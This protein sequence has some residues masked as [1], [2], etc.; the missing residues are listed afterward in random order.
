[1]LDNNQIKQ[2]L[3]DWS[4][5]DTAP[6]NAVAREIELPAELNE[7]LAF[8][9]QGVR[10]CG[11]STL[12]TQLPKIYNIPLKQCYFCNFEDTRLVNYLDHSLL[13]AIYSVARAEIPKDKP[14]YFFLD[15]IQNVENWEKWIYTKL[16]RP[17]NNYFILTG[18]NSCLLSG[19]FASSLTG[20]HLTIE[21]FPFSFQEYKELY[22]ERTI[23]EYLQQGG[24]PQP[25]IS[26][27]DAKKI[28]QEYFN[29]IIL[30]DIAKRSHARN[31]QAIKQVVQMVYESTGSEFSYRKIAASTD[32]T[33]DTIKSYLT[34]AEQAYLLFECPYFAH[35][36][37]KRANKPKKYYPIDIGMMHAITTS[38]S[39]NLGKSLELAVFLHLKQ[40]YDEVFYW[41]ETGKGE[42]DFI[43]KENNVSIPIQV[44]TDTPKPRHNRALDN[45]YDAHPMSAE[46]VFISLSNIM[47]F[48]SA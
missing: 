19:E 24:F 35:S 27:R 8:V 45:F 41:S 17:K 42:V 30:R 12:M 22:S 14:C 10:R 46:P 31:P 6:L 38:T 7:R 25:L 33:V 36:L 20:R 15:E 13:D 5:W 29:D 2:I 11:K 26:Y 34:A 23:E 44:T 3:A 32:L 18:S 1:M 28:L 40:K 43:V 9:I 4:F 47:D 37:R 21:L 16:E 39:A 48:L